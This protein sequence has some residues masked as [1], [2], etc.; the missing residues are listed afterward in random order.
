MRLSEYRGGAERLVES[1][2]LSALEVLD[3]GSTFISESRDGEGTP[4]QLIQKSLICI[5]TME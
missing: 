4:S 5:T 2:S 1:Q 3:A